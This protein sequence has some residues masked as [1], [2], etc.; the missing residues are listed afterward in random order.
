[1]TGPI[2]IL[3]GG[4]LG[5][6]LGLAGAPLG[7]SF[8]FLDEN[9]GAPASMVGEMIVAPY[10]DQDALA[11]LCDGAQVCT[12]EFE[13]VPADT[14]A[15]IA[16]RIPVYPPPKALEVAQDRL[17]ERRLFADLGIPAPDFCTI[18]SV[19]EL[20]AAFADDDSPR[21]L[22]A[23]RLGY[24]G[25]GQFL[26]SGAKEAERALDAIGH[27]PAILDGFVEFERE[28]SILAVRGR[29]G[30]DEERTAFY[31][32][33]HN[34][35]RGGILRVSRAPDPDVTPDVEALAQDYARRIL[36]ALDY[37]GVLAVEF[38]WVRGPDGSAQLLANEIAPRVHNS[39]HWTIEGAETSQFENHLRAVGGLPLGPTHA[40]GASAMVNIIGDLPRTEA[41]LA[42][43]GAHL[44]LYGKEPRPLR[45]IGHVTLRADS[46]VEVE[47]LLERFT[48][49]IG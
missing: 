23:R 10:D 4:Q 25:K 33:T 27:V 3:G 12:Y 11:R 14:A 30:S 5:R 28:V 22:K 15:F 46:A 45:K 47:R 9:Q 49:I 44:H 7:Q 21:L 35:H 48:R 41:V 20:R 18:D 34:I 43:P 2:A 26:L 29:V 6:M 40:V 36:D 13:N 24:D 17:L 19:E 39:G 42:V 1:M 37:V 32:L 16:E 8:R 31:P 38:F